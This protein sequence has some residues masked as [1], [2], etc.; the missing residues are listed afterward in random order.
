MIKTALVGILAAL[1][2]FPKA[3]RHA[4]CRRRGNRWRHRSCHPLR[5][6]RALVTSKPPPSRTSVVSRLAPCGPEDVG[7]ARQA[8]RARSRVLRWELRAGA[9]VDATVVGASVTAAGTCVTVVGKGYRSPLGLRLHTLVVPWVTFNSSR[10]LRGSGS[11]QVKIR[12]SRSIDETRTRTWRFSTGNNG[13]WTPVQGAPAASLCRSTMEAAVE[14]RDSHRPQ[15]PES[16]SGTD[17]RSNLQLNLFEVQPE[18]GVLTGYEL[19]SAKRK[20]C[21]V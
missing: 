11:E 16:Q 21:P 6:R 18:E 19:R 10:S 4:R 2:L 17:H 15:G 9:A 20:F 1:I 3:K 7:V 12:P 14:S 5:P 8:P 13:A